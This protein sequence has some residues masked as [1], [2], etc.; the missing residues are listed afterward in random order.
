[1]AGLAGEAERRPFGLVYFFQQ[2]IQHSG[3]GAALNGLEARNKTPRCAAIL[4]FDDNIYP[5][6]LIS[7]IISLNLYALL[8]SVSGHLRSTFLF[9]VKSL[10]LETP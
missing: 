1:M 5:P 7:K 3:Q 6:L 8:A 2:A 4:R 9:G 10:T